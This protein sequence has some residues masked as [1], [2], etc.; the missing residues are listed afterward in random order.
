MT[1]N[2]LE[3]DKPAA[4]QKGPDAIAAAK[5]PAAGPLLE[6]LLALFK[7]DFE[8]QLADNPEF[9]TQAGFHEHDDALQVLSPQSFESRI[10]YNREVVGALQSILKEA[11]EAGGLSPKEKLY[12]RLLLDAA[13][14]EAKGIDLGLHLMP[15]NSIGIGGVHE[16]FLEVLQ[17]MQFEGEEDVKKY[18]S[19]LMSFPDQVESFCNLL[20]YG[21]GMRKVTASK[22]MMRRVPARLKELID[23]DLAELQEPIKGKDFVSPEL[24]EQIGQAIKNCFRPALQRLLDF[25]T[26]FYDD[27]I[28]EAPGLNALKQGPEMYAACL[29]FH[30]N[31]LKTAQEIHELGLREVARIEN[32]MR[33]EVMEVLGFSGSVSDF[34]AS[35]KEDKSLF[36]ESEEAL[37]QGYRELVDQ[38]TKEL[39]KYFSALPKAPLE[40]VPKMGGPAAYYFAGTPDGKRPGRFYVNVS[41]LSE[42]P[43]YEMTALALH[44]GVP[45]HHFQMSL[46]LEND[47]L[48]DF[49]RYIEDRRYEF[50]PARRPL[51]AGYLEG[52]ALYCE[53]LGE[54]MGMYRTPHDLFGRLSME[55]MRAVRLVVDTG[56]HH[57]GW[58][59]EKA[60]E[61]MCE[62]T[63]MAQAECEQ[64]CHRY[65]AWPGQAC[66]YKVGQLAIEEMRAKAETALGA[67]F[68]LAAFHEVLLQTGPV[69]LD[70]LQKEVEEWA[71]RQA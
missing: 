43:K 5:D 69:P 67:K 65:A 28:R 63:G 30:T 70:I 50:G 59:V 32:R 44:E 1:F 18:L 31:T 36:F 6:R 21:A 10:E 4:V 3:L 41:R 2:P 62:E 71:R 42:R 47:S 39:P 66:A 19:R 38:I 20:A 64:E 24:A 27:R 35:L 12:A 37:L 11:D 56:I 13:E 29:Q 51:Y 8:H 46:A 58:T 48:P 25:L 45:G 26:D 15:L 23:G 16:N 40:V 52:W 9:A 53:Q 34:A 60:V 7:Q 22:S 17:W 54:E 61:Y 33:K 57:H 14:G 49:L 55:M 68:N